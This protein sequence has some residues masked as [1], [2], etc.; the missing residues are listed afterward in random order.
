MCVLSPCKYSHK[1]TNGL[2]FHC[3][4]HISFMKPNHCC[5]ESMVSEFLVDGN[6][7]CKIG[8]EFVM[9]VPPLQRSQPPAYLLARLMKRV[10]PSNP[11]TLLKG[12]IIPKTE[13]GR[14]LFFLPWEGSTLVGTTDSETELTMMPRPK[15]EDVAFLTR[16]CNR[17]IDIGVLRKDVRASWSGIRPLVRFDSYKGRT[18][19]VSRSHVIEVSPSGLVTVMGGKWTTFR[20]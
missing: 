19:D 3:R 7:R 4:C 6:Q 10:L 13:D 8:S 9:R 1:Q 20:R 16:E 12:L 15:E 14:V 2:L 5:P 18:A 17:Y 11:I